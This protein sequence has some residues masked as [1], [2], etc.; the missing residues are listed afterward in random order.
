M[1]AFAASP[2][3]IAELQAD[4]KALPLIL[5]EGQV[6]SRKSYPSRAQLAAWYSLKISHGDG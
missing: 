3:V 2:T 4:P 5:V 1:A 6:K